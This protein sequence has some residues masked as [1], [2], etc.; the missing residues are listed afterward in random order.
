LAVKGCKRYLGSLLEGFN[1]VLRVGGHAD[2][3]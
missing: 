2:H 1:G 3:G